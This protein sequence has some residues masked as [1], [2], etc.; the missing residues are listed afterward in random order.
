LLLSINVLSLYMHEIA[1]HTE[2]SDGMALSNVSVTIDAVLT[3]AHIS[4]LSACLTAID[5]IFDAFLGMEVSEIRCLPV[6]NFVRVAYAVV[7]LI[8]MYF[9]ASAADS[10]LGK[11][12]DKNNMK[13][14][15]HLENLLAKFRATAADDRS[16]PTAKFLVILV[17]LRSWFQRQSQSQSQGGAGAG[18]GMDNRCR[19]RASSS[20]IATTT[21]TRQGQGS[22]GATPDAPTV[23]GANID[24]ALRSR[25]ADA[26]TPRRTASMQTPQPTPRDYSAT[27]NTPLQLLSEVAAANEGAT[28]GPQTSSGTTPSSN[29]NNNNNNSLPTWMAPPQRSQSHQPLQQQQQQQQQQ[30]FLYDGS[31]S[32]ATG[33]AAAAAGGGGGGGG[34]NNMTI[35]ALGWPVSIAFGPTFGDFDGMLGD[36]G[37]SDAVNL[38]L[39]GIAD[40]LDDGGMGGGA[41]GAAAG[42]GGTFIGAEDMRSMLQEPW[43][44][45]LM[46]QGGGPPA[47]F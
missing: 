34:G 24:P 35:D 42:G 8:K 21:T 39:G 14:E 47:F 37:F 44:G 10:E 33:T 7:V 17:M 19:G 4:A 15:Q 32:T 45:E 41:A 43:F 20:S 16:R 6:F 38:T 13:V 1:L 30:P 28:T 25:A 27:A 22:D 40:G 3:P 26:T 31:T 11:V 5:G 12:I 29:N 36:S 18:G 9:A 46:G 23:V 2:R